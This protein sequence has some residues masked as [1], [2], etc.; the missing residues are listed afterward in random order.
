MPS[1]AASVRVNGRLHLNSAQSMKHAVLYAEDDENDAYFMRRVF[2]KAGLS[3]SLHIVE[4]GQLAVD[5]LSGK[6]DF[7]DRTLHPMP[8]LVLL[9]VKMPYLTGLEVLRWIRKHQEFDDLAVIMLTSSNQDRDLRDAHKLGANG[10]LLKPANADNLIEP[11]RSL[12]SRCGETSPPFGDRWL[13]FAGNL[14]P[15][16]VE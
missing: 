1:G 6:G 10:Y 16:R 7:A 15:P 2:A 8:S 13:T 3:H 5:Y 14:Q 4:N 9:D 12:L 11:L